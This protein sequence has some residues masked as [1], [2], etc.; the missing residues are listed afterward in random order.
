MSN[1]TG[2]EVSKNYICGYDQFFIRM[3]LISLWKPVVPNTTKFGVLLMK[4]YT[5]FEHCIGLHKDIYEQ[6]SV[7]IIKRTTQV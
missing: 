2:G 1:N 3:G 7:N 6:L 4:Y 5:C